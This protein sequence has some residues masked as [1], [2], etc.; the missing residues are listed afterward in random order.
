MSVSSALVRFAAVAAAS[1]ALTGCAPMRV[2][3]YVERGVDLAQYHTYDWD[4]AADQLVTG[5]PRLDDNPFFHERVQAD[6]DRQ[7]ATRGFE[8]TATG[9]PDLRIHYHVSVRQRL[10]VNGA[11]RDRGYCRGNDC[12]P[13]V[14]EAG[15]LL[16]DLVDT[17]T[18]RVVWRGWAE[19][20]VDGLIDDQKW[21]EQQIDDAVTRI[22]AGIPRRL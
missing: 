13:Y 11:D 18:S 6:V 5:D 2:N 19:G 9:V 1:I 3:S 20:S 22:L 10:D 17:H 12:R 16:L 7:L 4:P 14:Y 8:K 21:M 15:T